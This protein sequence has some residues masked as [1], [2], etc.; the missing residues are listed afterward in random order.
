MSIIYFNYKLKLTF[1]NKNNINLDIHFI[2]MAKKINYF[3]PKYRLLF[4]NK[5]YKK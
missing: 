2:K 1:I 5:C 3:Q 4:Y